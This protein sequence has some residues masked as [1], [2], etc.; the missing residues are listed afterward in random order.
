MAH[1]PAYLTP[2]QRWTLW[3][4]AYGEPIRVG[5]YGLGHSPHSFIRGQVEG[6]D[7]SGHLAALGRLRCIRYL[8]HGDVA[9]ITRQG[10]LSL[11]NPVPR[12]A[13]KAP[14]YDHD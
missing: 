14:A 12:P 7:V 2:M 5:R 4:V 9:C 1:G 6:R 8:Q 3:H 13:R 11:W 10:A